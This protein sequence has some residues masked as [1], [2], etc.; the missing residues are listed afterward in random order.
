MTHNLVDIIQK[1]YATWGLPTANLASNTTISLSQFLEYLRDIE[2]LVYIKGYGVVP[3]SFDPDEPRLSGFPKDPLWQ[4]RSCEQSLKRFGS[5][6]VL[7]RLPAF[8]QIESFFNDA[9]RS[10][11]VY[12]FPN[13][14]HQ[15]AVGVASISSLAIDTVVDEATN[16]ISFSLTLAEKGIV[17]SS[18][19]L[20]H[21]AD[22]PF[23]E[24]PI[25]IPTSSLIAQEVHLFP[26]VPILEQCSALVLKKTPSFHVVEDYILTPNSGAIRTHI[27]STTDEPLPL[28]NLLLPFSLK[29]VGKCTCGKDIL[30]KTT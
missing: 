11:G 17:P 22:T 30:E 7:F 20:I 5:R 18:W 1:K 23:W 26:C 10:V 14:P 27:T 4:W 2:H 15:I 3:T 9:C 16:A 13:A 12:F 28:F 21:R 25:S 24:V 29:I 8:W 6:S 19:I